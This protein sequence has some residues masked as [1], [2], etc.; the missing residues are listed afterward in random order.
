[1]KRI[2]FVF[3]ILSL[4]TIST[5]AQIPRTLSYQGVLTDTSGNKRPDGSYNFTFKLYDS[6]TAI[7]TE[8]KTLA[9]KNGLF[10][11]SLG[12]LSPFGPTV[13]FDKPYTLGIRVGT[14]SELLPHIPLTSVGYSMNS[15]RADTATF[16]L[17]GQG[18]GTWMQKDTNIYRLNGNVGI[19]TN[20]PSGKLSIAGSDGYQPYSTDFDGNS[21]YFSYIE[22]TYIDK[23]SGSI[24]FRMGTPGK[25]IKRKDFLNP[26]MTIDPYG[27]IGIGT[28]TP[29]TRLEVVGR[30]RTSVLEITGGSDLAEPF[31]MSNQEK[32]LS[33]TI[34]VIDKDNPG[35]LKQSTEPYDKR[36]AGIIS[37][38]GGI[39][40][41]LTLDQAGKFTCGQHVA[42]TGKVYA[43][44]STVNG[45]IEPGD[46]LTT[47]NIPG[48]A[49]KATDEM[50]SRG[51]IIGKAM[52]SLVEGTGLVL[53]L[54]NLQ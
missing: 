11:T 7:W 37:G 10:S 30:T 23:P 5:F 54:V 36:V 21:I 6:T 41:G 13:K 47:S 24:I 35:K 1:M 32:L 18:D 25:V 28:T 52:S 44:V 38:A 12:D 29:N 22:A 43:L 42:L 34:V 26:A 16:S 31:E 9:V 17:T 15:I 46:L 51:T 19:G 3:V 50:K 27:N 39:N 40:P 53:V 49:M 20:K 45:V 48:Y 14:E 4:V 2:I 8:T 33:G